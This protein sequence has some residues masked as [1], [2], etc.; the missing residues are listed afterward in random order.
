M[1]RVRSAHAF[2]GWHLPCLEQGDPKTGDMP[3][4]DQFCE[5]IFNL[6]TMTA[7]A[8]DPNTDDLMSAF[9]FGQTPRPYSDFMP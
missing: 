4:T 3:K 8:A 7:R 5:A 2:Y 9:D 1:W 6:P